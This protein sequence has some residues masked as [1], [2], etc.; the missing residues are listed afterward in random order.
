MR[1]R[2]E[3]ADGYPQGLVVHFTA[4]W[5]IKRGIWPFAF[6][7]LSPSDMKS[8]VTKMAR[9]YALRTAK[10]G[11][12]S[13]Y[14]FLVM[15][16]FGNIYQSRPLSKYGYHAG[17]SYWSGIGHSVSSK[18]AGVEILNAGKLEDR[19]GKWF[20]WFNL[21]VPTEH[22]RPYYEGDKYIGTFCKYTAEQERS[23]K[24]LCN[25]LLAYSPIRE[26]G[27][28]V[29]DIRYVVGHH[30]VAPNRKNDPMGSL[31]ISMDKFREDLL[32]EVF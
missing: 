12:K 6:P 27:S 21:E 9:E 8:K 32:N 26:N 17:K 7:L 16:V 4:G 2:G 22:T 10:G 1:T 23:L 15:D 18:L 19:N 13:G 11:A 29:F 14:N 28:R 24:K 25:E 20:T 30:E 5:A 31:S 3:Y